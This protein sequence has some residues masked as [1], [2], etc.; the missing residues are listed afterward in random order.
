MFFRPT[1]G[2]TSTSAMAFQKSRGR[3][4]SGDFKPSWYVFS[5]I[6]LPTS[7]RGC[8]FRAAHRD[9]T[10][11]G[12]RFRHTVTVP[13]PLPLCVTPIQTDGRRDGQ[14]PSNAVK[15]RPSTGLDGIRRES[16][17][18]LVSTTAQIVHLLRLEHY[19]SQRCR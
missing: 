10:S 14:H 11:R 2:K 16:T 6:K 7:S 18:K 5:S 4:V 19:N 1:T 12:R 8:P 3:T 17:T 13:V 15:L 9:R